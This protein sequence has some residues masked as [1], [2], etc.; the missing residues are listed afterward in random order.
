MLYLFIGLILFLDQIT[1]F[2]VQDKM[3]LNQSIT[4]IEH[5][6]YIHYVRNTGA[7]WSVLAGKQVLLSVIALLAV[8]GMSVYLYRIRNDQGKVLAK[9][10]LS[11]MI[12]GALGNLVDRVLFEYVRDFLSFY[13]LGYAFPVF[14]IADI[15]LSVGVALLLL[16]TVLEET[17][18]K[19]YG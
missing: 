9:Y 10:A 6:F 1:K 17:K 11:L 13:P 19:I 8:I 5:F 2:M 4:V 18:G 3:S 7:A 16:E 14:N 15:A 12:A